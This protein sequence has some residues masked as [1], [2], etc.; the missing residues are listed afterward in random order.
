MTTASYAPVLPGGLGPAQANGAAPTAKQNDKA[1]QA[2]HDFEAV[3]L[4]QML[5]TM[6]SGL[7]TDGMFG[8]GPGEGMFRSMLNQEY[9]KSIT[10]SGGIGVADAV[11]REM[12]KMQENRS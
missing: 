5:E 11:Y 3:F 1:H 6:T 12:L 10:K 2:A 9:A 8:G 4:S 7:K